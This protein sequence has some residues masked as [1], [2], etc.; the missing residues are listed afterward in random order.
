[1]P[2]GSALAVLALQISTAVSG[3]NSYWGWRLPFLFSMV[4]VVVGVYIRLGVLETPVFSKLLEVGIIAFLLF[5]WLSDRVGRNRVFGIGVV[6][7]FAFPYWLM[8]D[9]RKPLLVF[10]A[11]ALEFP[12]S[13]MMQGPFG[14]IAAEA[15]TARRRYSGATLSYQL[16]AVI[17]GGTSPVVALAL[18]TAY[19]ST[20]PIA[21]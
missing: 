6:A 1:M 4:L 13:G 9:T 15:F 19:H 11:F 20:V 2:A 10:L 21:T 5:G 16:A 17:F 12:I 14:A 7:L 3:Q 8:L 18:L